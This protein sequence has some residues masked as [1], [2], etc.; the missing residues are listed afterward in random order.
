MYRLCLLD[1][2][3]SFFHVNTVMSHFYSYNVYT[4]FCTV[5]PKHLVSVN[6][7]FLLIVS[8]FMGKKSLIV[9]LSIVPIQYCMGAI[10]KKKDF[11]S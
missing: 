6:S 8:S 3:L 1:L 2:S 11:F 7:K 9:H 10:L 5:R 4:C